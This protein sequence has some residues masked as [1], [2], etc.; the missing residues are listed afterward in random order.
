MTGCRIYLVAHALHVGAGL[1]LSILPEG[2][3]ARTDND[4]AYIMAMDSSYLTSQGASY[5]AGVIL[6]SF[7]K[8][9]ATEGDMS[10]L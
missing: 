2:C 6:K 8:S 1:E 4:R 3:L 10:N 9:M 5:E 7:L